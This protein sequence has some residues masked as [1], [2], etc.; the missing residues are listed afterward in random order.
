MGTQGTK[1]DECNS[2]GRKV[3]TEQCIAVCLIH[4]PF[5]ASLQQKP[6]PASLPPIHCS[7][8]ERGC[9]APRISGPSLT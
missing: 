3:G 7:G 5:P 4:A 9:Y 6:I 8:R 2:M 1:Q